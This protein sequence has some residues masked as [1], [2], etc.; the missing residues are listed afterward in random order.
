MM[1]TGSERLLRVMGDVGDDLVDTAEKKI[2]SRSVRQKL[3]PVAACLVLVAGLGLLSGA[4]L[5]RSEPSTV[6]NYDSESI[7]APVPEEEMPPQTVEKNPVAA[8][9]QLVFRGTVYYVE[10]LYTKQQAEEL[11]GDVLG[12]VE[13]ADDPACV[14]AQVYLRRGAQVRKNE[15]EQEVPL[16]IFV[17]VEDGYRYCLTYFASAGAPLEYE[18]LCRLWYA[19]KL[20]TLTELLVI[21]LETAAAFETAAALTGQQLEQMFLLTLNMERSAGKRSEDLDRYLWHDGSRYVIPEADIRRQLDKYLTGYIW[22]PQTLPDYRLDS[23]AVEL[24]TLE[25]ETGASAS[26]KP[27][28]CSLEEQTKTLTLVVTAEE[29]RAYRF[30]FSG[31]TYRIISIV[32]M[33]E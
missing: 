29:T 9:E 6:P 33:E 16:E 20:D 17:Q 15:Q 32:T 19:G 13:T 31:E 8:R 12:T 7:H 2:F 22:Q 21:P 1:E 4:Y 28:Q 14:G 26:V 25:V 3:L 27:E 23:C 18:A 11:L 24:D 10:A 5:F 30:D